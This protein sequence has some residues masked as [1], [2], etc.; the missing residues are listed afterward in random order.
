MTS[1]TQILDN[2]LQ[3]H[4]AGRLSEAASGYFDALS[5]DPRH[6]DALHLLGV[7][8]QQQ[9]KLDVAIEL[10]QKAIEQNPSIAHYRHNLGNTY[11]Q[12]GCRLEAAECYLQAIALKQDYYEAYHGLGNALTSL[13]KLEVAE[14]AYRDAIRINPSASEAYYNLGRI[15]ALQGENEQAAQQYR[16]AI[17]LDNQRVEYFFNLGGTLF[18]QGKISEAMECYRQALELRP[19]DAELHNNLGRAFAVCGDLSAAVAS[20]QTSISLNP[21]YA[22]AQSN[23][24]VVLLQQGD[25]AQAEHHCRQA[26]QLDPSS[27]EAQYSL[28]NVFRWTYRLAE[29]VECYRK[30]LQ[31]QQARHAEKRITNSPFTYWQVMN[32]LALSLNESGQVD[33]SLEC[34]REALRNEPGNGILHTN[35][36]FTLLMNGHFAEGWVEHEWRDKIYHHPE[37]NFHCPQWKGE[38]LNGDKILLH[39]EQGFGDTLQFVRYAPLLA[40]RGAIVIL[41][42]PP[43]LHRLISRIPGVTQVIAQGEPFPEISWHCP[44]MSLPLAF[45]TR[46]ETIPSALCYLHVPEKEKEKTREVWPADGLRVGLAWSG[47]PSNPVDFSRS[48]HLRHMSTLSEVSGISFYSLQVGEAT[49]QLIELEGTFKIVDACSRDRDFADSAAFIAGLDLV[50][51]VDTSIAHLAGALGVPVW[52]LLSHSRADWRWFKKRSD[53]PWYP[54][55]RLFRQMKDGDWQGLIEIVRAE[56]Q[57]LAELRM[58]QIEEPLVNLI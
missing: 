52:I 25:L 35:F 57:Q 27:P 42:V 38:V 29:S 55:A 49:K 8:A 32:N 31:L 24:G 20:Y 39:A 5:K 33:A 12:Q 41:E 51:A 43:R 16:M 10:M 19:D 56:L 46:F 34:Y 3:H 40:E 11:L 37:R 1:I 54:S 6:S 23:L 18:H 48:M 4:Q 17:Q 9:G 14:E 26:V 58:S 47:N 50:I 53:S 15:F 13:G 44:L 36:A 7:V 21:M 28:G 45:S 30:S 2:A 22:E